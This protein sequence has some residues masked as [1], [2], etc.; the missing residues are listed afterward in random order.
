MNST[1]SG[2]ASAG[3]TELRNRAAR[4]A[5]KRALATVSR[6]EDKTLAFVNR[7]QDLTGAEIT[8]T[9]FRRNLAEEAELLEQ[10]RGIVE[11]RDLNA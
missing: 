9:D 8:R 6:L 10:L 11:S 2:D 5:V 4:R 3:Q 7:G 1:G